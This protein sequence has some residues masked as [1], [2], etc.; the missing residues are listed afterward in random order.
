MGRTVMAATVWDTAVLHML[1]AATLDLTGSW[2]DVEGGFCGSYDS[3]ITN[4]SS[5][6]ATL[7]LESFGDAPGRSMA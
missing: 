4:S 1:D 5:N 6:A 2:L 3:T 7:D